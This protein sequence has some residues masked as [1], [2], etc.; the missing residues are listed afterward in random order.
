M[1]VAVVPLAAARGWGQATVGVVQVRSCAA[2][3]T[4][5]LAAPPKPQHSPVVL[6][7][8]V[9]SMSQ[10]CPVW[11]ALAAADAG[12]RLLSPAPRQSSFLWGYLLTLV[13]GGALADRHGA[14]SVLAV[15]VALW[16]AATLVTPW[17]ARHSLGALLTARAVMGLG[18][19]VALPC[20][21]KMMSR[22]VPPEE[23]SRAVGMAMGGF[24]LGNVAGFLLA[25][26]LMAV[27]E[28]GVAGPFLAFGL[29][30]YAWLAAWSTGH[31]NIRRE[32]LLHITANR[33]VKSLEALC[34]NGRLASEEQAGLV[35][36][37]SASSNVGASLARVLSRAP[38]WAIICAN[39]INNWGYFVLLS[40]M[41]VY[42]VTVLGVD[43]R[44]AAWFSA[45]PWA[46]M[47]AAGLIAGA[48]SDE[49][50]SRRVSTTAIRKAMQTVG[51]LGPAVALWG[52]TK[53]RTA[54]TAA[55][56]LTA[57]L[58]LS[59]FSQAGF[60]VNYQDIGPRYV[61]LLHGISNTAGTAAGI[62]ST[63]S[64]G[65]L[66]GKLG[67][68]QSVLTLMSSLYVLGTLIWLTF[69]TGELVFD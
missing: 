20:M 36:G 25:P 29:L 43:L 40:W 24:H 11:A 46:T 42:F 52:L 61:G 34:N 3:A 69:S 65:V 68:F 48:I 35:V 6:V 5:P 38:T 62:M 30:G 28:L 13:A 44:R 33:P 27:P 8:S 45:V 15:G 19:G 59:S 26:V 49:L 21:N 10:A 18:E 55:V 66:L 4:T 9:T 37:G 54:Q 12:P 41:P 22:W 50:V 2:M 64:T 1:S 60:L 51:F 14:K 39:F 58:G 31:P 7:H 67:S 56:W 53:A 57:A 17:A 23:R 47:A 32:E 63:L 16:S